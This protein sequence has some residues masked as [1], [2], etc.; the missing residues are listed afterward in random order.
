MDDRNKSLL[1]C[2]KPPALPLSGRQVAVRG[3]ALDWLSSQAARWRMA[4]AQGQPSGP[5]LFAHNA[6][7]SL[8]YVSTYA[9]S[10]FLALRA[11]SFRRGVFGA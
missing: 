2:S 7:S 1:S 3:A 8:S 9:P 5:G 6:A 4:V 10:F 11:N